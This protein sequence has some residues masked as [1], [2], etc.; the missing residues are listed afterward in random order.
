MTRHERSAASTV[1][2]K[3]AAMLSLEG[4]IRRKLRLAERA[5]AFASTPCARQDV[6]LQET[7]MRLLLD[8]E[9]WRYAMSD[10]LQILHDGF[11]DQRSVRS[12]RT[13]SP[14]LGTTR[15]GQ[16]RTRPGGGEKG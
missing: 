3:S 8:N 16:Q 13:A 11:E 2:D 1:V 15:A 14:R 6:A 7:V 12:L 4:D 10:L 5:V 9:E